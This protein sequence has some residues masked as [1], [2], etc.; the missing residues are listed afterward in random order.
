MPRYLPALQID[1]CEGRDLLVMRD[2]NTGVEMYHDISLDLH[3]AA[4]MLSGIKAEWFAGPLLREQ[5]DR[6]LFKLSTR[7]KHLRYRH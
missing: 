3:E 5:C 6:V 7:D 2:M 1:L 4:Q